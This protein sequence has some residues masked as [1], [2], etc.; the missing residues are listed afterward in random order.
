M[1]LG[2]GGATAVVTGGSKGIGLAIAESLAAEG[3]SVAV[4]AR[5]RRA[6]DAAA[7]NSARW[8]RQMCWRSVSIWPVQSRSRRRS[9]PSPRPG[10]ALNVLIH[11]VG[12]DAGLFEDLDDADWQE[13][14]RRR[15]NVGGAFNSS[16]AT[17]APG[18]GMGPH[19]HPVR[20]LDPTPESTAYRLH[21]GEGG[22]VERNEEP[23]QESWS[24]GILVNCVCPGTIVTASFTETLKDTLASEGLDSANPHD[25]MR[26]VE[27]TFGHPCRRRPGRPARGDRIDDDLSRLPTQRLCHRCDGQRRRRLRLRLSD[28]T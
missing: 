12:P 20:A 26:W 16:R 25:V 11:T 21:G 8:V 7:E 4:M 15:H 19:R 3:A 17:V 18:G 22:A 6:L 1:D 9:R 10:G 27:N 14:V 28:L 5:N 13:G 2:L 24:E 23:L